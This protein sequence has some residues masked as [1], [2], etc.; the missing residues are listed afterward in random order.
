MASKNIDDYELVDV[1]EPQL[2]GKSASSGSS[3]RTWLTQKAILTLDKYSGTKTKSSI[4]KTGKITPDEFV[5]AGDYLVENFPSWRWCKGVPGKEKSCLPPGKQYLITRN[6]SCIPET[7]A[8]PITQYDDVEWDKMLGN[9]KIES[10]NNDD[11]VEDLTRKTNKVVLD[12]DD[13]DDDLDDIDG[14]EDFDYSGAVDDD[15]VAVADEQTVYMT[16]S[17]DIHIT[18]DNYYATPRVWLYGYDE[19]GKPLEG[20][21]WQKDFSKSHVNKTVTFEIH[22]HEMFSCPTIHPCN[23]ATA[24][25]KIIKMI[26]VD[27]ADVDVRLYLLIFLKLIQTIIP[28]IACDFTG[29]LDMDRVKK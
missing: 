27:G 23:H 14:L 1:E 7:D 19:S 8:G 2:D 16:R 22:T 28:S 29:E 17:Y 26:Q 18:Y 10:L 25:L 11:H 6:I 12:V 21:E 9:D 13:D 4:N 15:D 3:W 24:M 20:A 5:K